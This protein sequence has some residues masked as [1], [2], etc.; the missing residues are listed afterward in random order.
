MILVHNELA[1]LPPKCMGKLKLAKSKIRYNWKKSVTNN[2]KHYF[3]FSSGK[4]FSLKQN[5]YFVLIALDVIS[6]LR[7][8]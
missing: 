6:G 5:M 8:V 7:I 4:P 2:V 3:K 1:M